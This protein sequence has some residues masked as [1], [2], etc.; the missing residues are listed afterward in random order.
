MAKKYPEAEHVKHTKIITES[1][2]QDLVETGKENV[3]NDVVDEVVNY[4]PTEY[5]SH[6]PANTVD[7]IDSSE[8]ILLTISNNGNNMC[9]TYLNDGGCKVIQSYKQ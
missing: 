6:S 2:I 8:Q 1:E 5:S 9:T 7:Q 3:K 4:D